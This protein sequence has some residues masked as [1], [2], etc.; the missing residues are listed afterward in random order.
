MVKM[1]VAAVRERGAPPPRDHYE[2]GTG[3]VEQLMAASEVG[4][5]PVGAERRRRLGMRAVKAVPRGV[6]LM[7]STSVSYA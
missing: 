5:A 2:A 4:L 3:R 1:T 6:A 7:A